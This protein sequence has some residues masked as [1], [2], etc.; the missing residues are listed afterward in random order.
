M[1]KQEISDEAIDLYDWE[2]MKEQDSDIGEAV[3]EVLE[4]ALGNSVDWL[5]TVGDAI[6]NEIHHAPSAN[7]EEDNYDAGVLEGLDM[8]LKIVKDLMWE[9]AERKLK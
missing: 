3:G 6:K 9:V 4:R 1:K 2:M 8:A 7:Y 5:Q